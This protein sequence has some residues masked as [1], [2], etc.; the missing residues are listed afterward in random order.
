MKGSFHH[1]GGSAGQGRSGHASALGGAPR[2]WVVL[3]SAVVAPGQSPDGL[4]L[5]QNQQQQFTDD[6]LQFGEAADMDYDD[7]D[8]AVLR[9]DEIMSSSGG[10]HNTPVGEEEASLVTHNTATSSLH[11]GGS[12]SSRSANTRIAATAGI[13]AAVPQH[14]DTV[15][16]VA[17]HDMDEGDKGKDIP[18]KPPTAQDYSVTDMFEKYTSTDTNIP[19]STGKNVGRSISDFEQQ[20]Q[21]HDH[22]RKSQA[23]NRN[24]NDGDEDLNMPPPPPSSL[25]P[26]QF[27]SLVS[28]SDRM[29]VATALTEIWDDAISM[30]HRQQQQ[31]PYA[32]SAQPPHHQRIPPPGFSPTARDMPP[33]PPRH[34]VEQISGQYTNYSNAFSF[35][36]GSSNNDIQQSTLLSPGFSAMTTADHSLF[37]PPHYNAHQTQP[38]NHDAQ[39]HQ[40]QQKSFSFAVERPWT[41]TM[42]KS[43]DGEEI[44][45]LQQ[46]HSQGLSSAFNTA[47]A[48]YSPPI[49]VGALIWDHSTSPSSHSSD[50]HHYQQQQEQSQP[51]STSSPPQQP[52]P[53]PYKFVPK[54]DLHALYGKAP[55][56]KIISNENYHTWHN[57]DQAHLLRW[58]SALVCPIT[59]E[60]F[61]SGRYGGCL[62]VTTTTTT[63]AA[64]LGGAS[65]NAYWFG[66]KAFAEHGAAAVAFDCWMYRDYS[67][68]EVAGQGLLQAPPA[69]TYIGL[70][71]PYLELG[72]LYV[73]PSDSEIP[74]YIRQKIE[75]QQANIRRTNGQGGF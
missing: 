16:T 62:D 12:S 24:G 41:S 22:K 54:A 38:E 7:D 47:S 8:K 5:E 36:G 52:Q 55:R 72:A 65:R 59:A 35:S 31:Q 46:R 57:S 23:M 20:Q 45:R 64:S 4:Q 21:S 32:A 3:P 51:E 70:E 13:T 33:P 56:R 26:G 68:D 58:S 17:E 10:V 49:G 43:I 11:T 44:P 2:D 27:P 67:K 61:L 30:S 69:P 71:R 42:P 39:Q 34:S 14:Q 15:D 73:L 6:T 48:S 29:S 74:V 40:Q 1:F 50:R 28:D 60:I 63:S 37:S 53:Q 9:E 25:E 18:M 19:M 66:K 75:A